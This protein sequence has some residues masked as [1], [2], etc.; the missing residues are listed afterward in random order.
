MEIEEIELTLNKDARKNRNSLKCQLLGGVELESSKA[1]VVYLGDKTKNNPSVESLI[2]KHVLHGST[3]KYKGKQGNLDITTLKK[4]YTVSF[5]RLDHCKQ[6]WDEIRSNV[7]RSGLKIHL[8]KIPIYLRYI[9]NTYINRYM[10]Y[11]KYPDNTLHYL[12]KEISLA[13][14]L[15]N[16]ND[17]E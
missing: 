1:F 14:P 2:I 16:D 17:T 7:A 11:R 4:Y 10:F 5:A 15:N 12:L 13:Y 6:L 9:F 3:I 8:V